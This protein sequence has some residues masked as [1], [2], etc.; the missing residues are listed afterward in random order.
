V[1]KIRKIF[2]CLVLLC[3][4]L[5]MG[6]EP[7]SAMRSREDVDPDLAGSTEASA[8]DRKVD[9]E[10]PDSY[11]L[12]GENDNFKLFANKVS[13]AFKVQDK[14]S[15]Y[16]W[17][18]N[19][20]EK[21]EDDKLNKTWTAFAT[22]GFS[23]DYLDLKAQSVRLSITRDE[24]TIDFKQIEGGFEAVVS[25]PEPAISVGLVVK[26]EPEGVSV[27]IPF[28]TI[29]EENPEFKL[30]LIYLYPFMGATRGDS[31]PGYMFIPD[32]SG[33]LINFSTET[34][35]QNMF[36]GRYYGEDL[37]MLTALSF[38]ATVNRPFNL[39]IPV[40]GMVHGKNENAFISILEKGAS[41][42]ELQAHPA[43]II[44]NFNF[45]HNTFVYNQSYFQATNRSGAGVT[46]L[47][48]TTNAFD[49][50]MHY[51][52]LSGEESNYVG[53][54]RSYQQYLIDRGDLKKSLAG[55]E[56]ISIRLEF[57]GAEKTKVLFW[58]TSIPMTTIEQMATI[59]DELQIKNPEV[60]YYG[61][62]PK[63]ASTMPPESL[64][65]DKSLGSLGQLKALMNNVTA[66]GGK[67]YLYVD[68]QSAFVNEK[69]YS[70]RH[71]LAM[72]IT[73]NNLIGFNRN[74]VNFY[75]NMDALSKSYNSLI[76]D[77]Y[78]EIN[79][80]VALDGISR[81][82]YS[83]FK[84]GN[85]LNREDAITKYQE[86]VE[87][88]AGGR[89]FYSPNDY[90][91]KFMDAYYDIPISDSGYIYTHE[92]VPFLQIVFAGY[93]PFYGTVL[94]FS[95]DLK[96]DLLR[97]ADFGVYPSYFLTEEVTAKILKTSS[98]WIYSSSYGQWGGE[99]NSTYVWL[100]NLLGPVKGETIIARETLARGVVATTYSNGKMIIVN[101][102]EGPFVGRGMTI[103]GRDA[104]LKEVNP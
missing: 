23:I 13:L 12:V 81:M 67:F 75:L 61:W 3:L 95:S 63:G 47:Q 49:V 90:M 38:D 60:V 78:D 76:S 1:A 15:G 44:T 101:Y 34:K 5:G 21:G 84:P 77:I 94:N 20:D 103:A 26:L 45:I 40:Y 99:V 10:I 25:F 71:D 48:K 4:F 56:D 57:L 11:E 30:G 39:S 64:K 8:L 62:Q 51:R 104:V 46:T 91:F 42:G 50:K 74:K 2:H 96:A 7:L 22:S 14:R 16:I 24:N 72:S 79:A 33:T 17:E 52:F 88:N 83:D 35:A 31:V 102:N 55:G 68:P 66:D 28:E 27:D 29:K 98:S 87:Q 73:N 37:G 58:T 65:L 85:I 9:Q 80:G 82:I 36:Y 43:G 100:N 53:M 54:A 89:A 59:L 93:V 70:P 97:H 69:G 92:T 6:F 86:L 19:I 18:S 41:Y 32:G